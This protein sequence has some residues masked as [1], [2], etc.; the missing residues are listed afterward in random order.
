MLIVVMNS[1]AFISGFIG[2]TIGLSAFYYLLLFFVT[3][4][5][6]HPLTQFTSL[7]PWMSLLIIGF[8]IQVGLYKLMKSGFRL[9]LSQQKD[10]RIMARS[11]TAISAGAMVVCCA[12]HLVEILPVIGLSAF[13]LFLSD[14]QQELLIVGVV[15]NLIGIVMMIWFM[16]GKAK[17][18]LIFS[19]IFNFVRRQS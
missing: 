18:A 11:S 7:Q 19:Y 14:Y 5:P 1:K 10:G 8:G 16:A 4:D 12:H 13:A 15:S 17:P 6:L 2:G 3:K 9:S